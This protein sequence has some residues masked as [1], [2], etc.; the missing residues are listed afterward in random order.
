MGM[1]HNLILAGIAVLIM[2]VGLQLW[3][4]WHAH[5][6]SKGFVVRGVAGCSPACPP[7]QACQ[8]VQG[9]FNPAGKYVCA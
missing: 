9:P 2:M 6:G 3:W 4:G 8:W 7:G 1:K 5:G